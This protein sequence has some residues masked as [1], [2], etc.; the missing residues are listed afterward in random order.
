MSDIIQWHTMT[1][2]QRD[3]LVAEKIMSWQPVM[4]KAVDPD[5]NRYTWLEWNDDSQWC[6]W[7]GVRETWA[8]GNEIE[9]RALPHPAYTQSMD[10][11]WQV[12]Q[13]MVRRHNKDGR[14]KD[15]MQFAENMLEVGGWD[16]SDAW[17]EIYP[18]HEIFTMAAKWT[19]EAICIAALKVV[20]VDLEVQP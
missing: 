8:S 16:S 5:I 18:A 15:F 17:A 4:C 20:G 11:A 6:M 9:H 3:R 13:E 2:E 14:T 7:C 12:L 10:S 19:P 1:P